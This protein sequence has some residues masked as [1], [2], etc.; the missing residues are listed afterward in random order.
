MAFAIS[1]ILIGCGRNV[2]PKKVYLDKPMP[3]AVPVKCKHKPVDGTIPKDASDAEVLLKV[4][5]FITDK[6]REEERC[7]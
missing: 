3:Y 7:E 1:A 6:N 2:E 5:K 4:G